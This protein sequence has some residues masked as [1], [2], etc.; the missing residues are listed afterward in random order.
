[1]IKLNLWSYTRCKFF[2]FTRSQ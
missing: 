2:V 1:M